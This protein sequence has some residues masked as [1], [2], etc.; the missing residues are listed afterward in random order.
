[1]DCP[2]DLG[3]V[4]YS[5]R[6][7]LSNSLYALD[8]RPNDYELKYSSEGYVLKPDVLVTGKSFHELYPWNPLENEQLSISMNKIEATSAYF[9][10]YLEINNKTD[11]YL[12]IETMSFHLDTSILTTSDLI[13]ELPPRSVSKNAI[14]IHAG[15][16]SGNEKTIFS[17]AE[18]LVTRPFSKDTAERIF[19]S[20]GISAKY[21]TDNTRQTF[22]KTVERRYSEL[23]Q[24]PHLIDLSEYNNVKIKAINSHGTPKLLTEK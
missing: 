5:V 3:N 22:F 12:S 24:S 2:V 6:I 11:K 23:L 14:S 17:N 4:V 13:L 15:T 1:M 7:E 10:F 20:L 16:M 18:K 9:T 21:V 8:I 19:L